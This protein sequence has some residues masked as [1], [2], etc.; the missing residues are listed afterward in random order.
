MTTTTHT[1]DQVETVRAFNRFW[2]R[3]IGV[4]QADLLDTDFSLPEARIIFELAN[5]SPCSA[6]DLHQILKLDTGYLSRLTNGL[7]AQGLIE[8]VPDERDGRRQLLNLTP[9]GHAAFNDLDS[10]SRA[11]VAE[12]LDQVPTG[13][14]G[15]LLAAMTTI[16]TLLDGDAPSPAY[17][18]RPP[19]SGDLGWVVQRHG[20]LYDAEYGWDQTFEALVAS[21]VGNYLVDHD[22]HREACWIAERDGEPVGSVFCCR[23]D[24]HTAQLRLLLVEPSA[25]GLGIGSRLVE[26]CIGFA[27]RSGYDQIVLWTNDV[28]VDARRLYESAGFE[29]T[30]EEAHHSFGHDLIGQ[31]WALPLR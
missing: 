14:V 11:Q 8:S 22:P 26:E 5:R 24:D 10:R 15:R 30:E 28:L 6:V 19:R 23:R 29:L 12:M 27:R 25:R 16:R 31:Y 9:Q 20:I 4:L 7:K 13:D 17:V 3:Q 1:Q 2:T 18:L 21:V